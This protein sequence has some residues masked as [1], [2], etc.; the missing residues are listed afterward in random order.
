MRLIAI[1]VDARLRFII[2][3]CLVVVQEFN[4]RVIAVVGSLNCCRFGKRVGNAKE[5]F[6]A[7]YGEI[8]KNELDKIY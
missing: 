7:I 2:S 3:F 1:A 6:T 5:G 8:K 4:R